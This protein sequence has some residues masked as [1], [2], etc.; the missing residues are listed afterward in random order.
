MPSC[1]PAA[2]QGTG[3]VITGKRW[4]DRFTIEDPLQSLASLSG[5]DVVRYTHGLA[6]SA[7]IDLGTGDDMLVLDGLARLGDGGSARGGEGN[8]DLR[9]NGR[10]AH[11]LLGEG[12]DDTLAGSALAATIL[13]GG[14][15]NDTYVVRSAANI[16]LESP[17]SDGGNDSLIAVTELVRELLSTGHDVLALTGADL[18]GIA[19]GMGHAWI[20]AEGIENLTA[21]V[22]EG[23]RLPGLSLVGNMLDNRLIGDAGGAL[24]D[25]GAGDD[26]L[27][28]MDGN[29]RLLGGDGHDQ[30]SGGTGN[31]DLA[32]GSGDD[33]LSG[34]DGDDVLD[35]GDGDDRLFGDH[36]DDRLLGGNGADLLVASRGFDIIDGGAGDD[37]LRVGDRAGFTQLT[38]GDGA[39]R[40]VV[41]RWTGDNGLEI[42]DFQIG[43][44]VLDLSAWRGTATPKLHWSLEDGVTLLELTAPSRSLSIILHGVEQGDLVMGRDIEM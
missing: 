12:G 37:V 30:L 27:F 4:A 15:G 21:I 8:D 29:D 44:D 2:E 42:L 14:S 19:G 35:G 43:Q 18:S 40:F 36:G 33:M 1:P 32:G 22:W 20:V 34:G 31:D 24:L 17:G 16:V 23:A 3:T 28:G 5:D 38:G 11:H 9:S 39:D 6:P 41:E 25:G 13:E 7:A 10:D 26:T